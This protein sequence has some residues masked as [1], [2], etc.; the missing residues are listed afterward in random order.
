MTSCLSHEQIEA[1]AR[2]G[3]SATNDPAPRMH[4]DA[5]ATCREKL[6]ACQANF[7]YLDRFKPMLAEAQFA[8]TKT[9]TVTIRTATLG[10]TDCT[11]VA[12]DEI[13]R[14]AG[15]RIIRQISSGG[16]GVVYEAE[17]HVPHRTVALK[18]LHERSL[19][20]AASRLRFERECDLIASLR[21]PNIVVVYESGVADGR[22]YFA[23]EYID[24][25]PLDEFVNERHC[26]VVERVTLFAQICLA[27]T[28]AHQRGVMHR[29]LKCSN[30]LV[31]ADAKP[32][33]L[34]FG[35]AKVTEEGSN[36]ESPQVTLPGPHMMGTLEY[37]SPEQTVGDP[38]GIDIRTDV[39]SLGVMLYRLLTGQPPYETP[40]ND[41]RAA[42][43]N[44]Q[45]A[46]PQRPSKLSSEIGSELDAIIY[47]T[48]EKEPA[49][50]Y[51]S[52]AEL[53]QDLQAWL[54]GRPVSVKSTS[55]LYVLRKIAR[56]HLVASTIAAAVVVIMTSA[57]IIS[58]EFYLRAEY[59]EEQRSKSDLGATLSEQKAADYE[60]VT[61]SASRRTA[62]GW[63]L[64]AWHAQHYEEA[65]RYQATVRQ[66]SPEYRAMAFLLDAS[67]TA[68]QLH[69]D[70]P[71]DASALAYLVIGERLLQSD[72]PNAARESLKEGYDLARDDLLMQTLIGTRLQAIPPQ[73]N[74]GTTGSE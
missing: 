26:S 67:Y 23:M 34:D 33:V 11:P 25:K 72:Q 47:K 32:Y 9:E 14:I 42:I 30:V 65:R 55:A 39:Y 40:R 31:T 3:Q 1:L 50:R 52:A 68:E 27:V 53:E 19:V 28:A 29:D 20:S 61:F 46:I 5:C 57:S 17:Q 62:L 38:D 45:E 51:Q 43:E 69:R 64:A 35:L 74:I 36:R 70:L 12:S 16:Q 6:E 21:H 10:S 8:E 22:P 18:L 49:K 48:L 15:Y 58:F 7:A 56:K 73:K 54:D 63:F 24:G 37:M 59:A 60:D 2:G 44:I 66:D 4:L 71:R 13:E 41:L